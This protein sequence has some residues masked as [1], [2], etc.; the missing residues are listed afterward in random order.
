[1][2]FEKLHLRRYGHFTDF[3]L[4]FSANK[5]E[6]TKPSNRSI[7]DFHILYGSNEAGKSTTLAAITDLLFGFETRTRWNFL[8]SN[9]LLELEASI[10]QNDQSTIVRRF[11]RYLANSR[12]VRICVFVFVCARARVH[13]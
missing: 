2:R 10:K 4:D 11:K 6:T 5:A 9:E 8:H 7:I 1:M 3:S 13:V 12:G